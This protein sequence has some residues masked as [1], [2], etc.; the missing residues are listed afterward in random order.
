MSG[1]LQASYCGASELQASYCG[2]SELQASYCRASSLRCQHSNFKP[3]TMASQK[4]SI[5]VSRVTSSR[6]VLDKQLSGG[7]THC[8]GDEPGNP[9]NVVEKKRV[10]PLIDSDAGLQIGELCSVTIRQGSKMASYTAKLLGI[11]EELY[12]E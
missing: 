6:R 7:G 8:L 2:S 5:Q 1:E 4:T 10:K 9:R 3:A 12:T 11:G